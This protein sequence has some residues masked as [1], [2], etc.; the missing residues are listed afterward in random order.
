MVRERLEDAEVSAVGETCSELGGS[1][2]L[3]E[4]YINVKGL[5]FVL[6]NVRSLLPQI[7]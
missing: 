1:D 7:D 5:Y 4:V 6:L 2:D 3:F